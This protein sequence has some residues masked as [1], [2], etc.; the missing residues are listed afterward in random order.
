MKR[1]MKKSEMNAIDFLSK[2]DPYELTVY[3]GMT[4]ARH[5]VFSAYNKAERENGNGVSS[6]DH[7]LLHQ[8]KGDRVDANSA[9]GVDIELKF[10]HRFRRSLQLV[11]ALD[12]GDHTDFV[13]IAPESGTIV[14]SQLNG[15]YCRGDTLG[16]FFEVEHE[17]DCIAASLFTDVD[18]IECY[19]SQ[20]K[21]TQKISYFCSRWYAAAI[22]VYSWVVSGSSTSGCYGN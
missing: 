8:Y 7:A 12:C 1:A 14:G 4:L 5:H 21:C 16:N 19:C 20:R 9:M 10:Y 11:P 3:D 13:G 18:R 2:Y 15:N 6:A 22:L 17:W